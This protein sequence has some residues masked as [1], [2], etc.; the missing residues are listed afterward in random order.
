MRYEVSTDI[1]EERR[2]AKERLH[3]EKFS[4]LGRLAAGVAH[5]L[6]NFLMGI[7][8]CAQYCLARTDA[9]SRMNEILADIEHETLRCA[10]IVQDLR[11]ASRSDADPA[12]KM[13]DFLPRDGHDETAD[14]RADCKLN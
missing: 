8:N 14:R 6:N 4:A 5:E 11:V 3:I 13:D 7:L 9:G 12:G 1:S 2:F 10:A